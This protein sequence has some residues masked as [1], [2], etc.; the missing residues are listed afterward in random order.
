DL[1]RRSASGRRESLDSLL[2][3]FRLAFPFILNG[4]VL[5]QGIQ[6]I[7]HLLALKKGELISQCRPGLFGLLSGRIRPASRHRRQCLGAALSDERE[8]GLGTADFLVQP[9][10]LGLRLDKFGGKP[11]LG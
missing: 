4:A 9:V 8:S 3:L 11:F 5:S 2:E 1:A 7:F 6:A 10:Y